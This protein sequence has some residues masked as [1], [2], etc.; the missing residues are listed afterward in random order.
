[1]QTLKM[2][3]MRFW[4]LLNACWKTGSMGKTPKCLCKDTLWMSCSGSMWNDM[5]LEC[6][7]KVQ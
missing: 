1:M 6:T 7:S 2:N 3:A 5:T 4:R